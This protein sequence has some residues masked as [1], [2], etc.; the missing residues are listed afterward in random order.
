ML[1]V[2]VSGNCSARRQHVSP[3]CGVCCSVLDNVFL[4]RGGPHGACGERHNDKAHI[5]E[6]ERWTL[7][8]IL[9]PNAE[10]VA[11]RAL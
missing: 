7:N 10:D 11:C 2:D 1:S 5:E 8:M 4:V 3:L 9:E 6:I